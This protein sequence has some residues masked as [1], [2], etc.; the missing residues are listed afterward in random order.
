MTLDSSKLV[1]EIRK[2]GDPNYI[3]F[4]GF[5]STAS[6]AKTAWANAYYNYAK[7]AEDVSGDAVASASLNKT[8]F[9]DALDF[10]SKS[11][12]ENAA[13][14]FDDA[15]VAFW[16]GVTFAV[17]TFTTGTEACT[18]VGGTL[19][20]SSETTSA[21]TAI[22]ANVLKNKLITVFGDNT[23]IDS[24]AKIEDIA[25]AFHEA[26]TT[27]ITVLITGIDTTPSPS[28]PLPITNTCKVF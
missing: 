7:D 12:I 3:S 24:L 11:T 9:S 1:T 27:A 18:N 16:T 6:A 14:K 13:G 28:G 26:T 4:G 19:V 8:G 10:D 17:G 5:P 20:F 23:E 25:T 15:F 2:F 21:V 22:A